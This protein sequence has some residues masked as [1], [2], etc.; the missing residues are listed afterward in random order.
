MAQTNVNLSQGLSI[1]KSLD[2][3]ESEEDVK[4]SPGSVFSIY[5]VNTNAAARWLKLYNA[6]AANTTVG[7]TVPVATFYL[8]ASGASPLKFD[9]RTGL[10]F[11]TAICAAATTGVADND[12]GAPG[13]NE[14][15]VV[16]GYA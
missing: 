12:T 9:S 6:T 16:I 14:V 1:F 2:L 8:P 10:T 11:D 3:D 4:T 7:T 5:A 13:A 15:V